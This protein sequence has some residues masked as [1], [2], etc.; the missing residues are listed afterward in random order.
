MRNS[1]SANTYLEG[2]SIDP[3]KAFQEIVYF[4]QA[5][6]KALNR[7]SAIVGLSGGLDSSLT[8]A[9]AVKSLGNEL[10]SLHYLPERDSKPIHRKHA[11]HVAGQLGLP[12]P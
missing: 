9:L 1:N 2:L 10:V 7:R 11:K 12:L 8:A 3:E 5:R 6:F 4:I